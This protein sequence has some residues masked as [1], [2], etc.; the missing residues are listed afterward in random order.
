MFYIKKATVQDITRTFVLNKEAVDVFFRLNL[1]MRNDE[2]YV[3]M[4]FLP[5]RRQEKVRIVLKQDP[6][7]FFDRFRLEP[8]DLVL[9]NKL[10]VA[11]YTVSFIKKND[12]RFAF[13]SSILNRF[14]YA[15]VDRID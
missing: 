9:F 4:I 11:E 6:R 13:L 2:A 3:S 15:I 1:L 5:S 10:G 8:G 12:S 7:I 14:N